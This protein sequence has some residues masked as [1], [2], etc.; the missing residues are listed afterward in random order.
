MMINNRLNAIVLDPTHTGLTDVATGNALVQVQQYIQDTLVSK[1]FTEREVDTLDSLTI[2]A[3]ACNNGPLTVSVLTTL[4]QDD[5]LK[6]DGTVDHSDAS[7][8]TQLHLQETYVRSNGVWKEADV[9]DLSQPA[10]SAS[11]SVI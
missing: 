9:N 2:D 1:G 5:Y 11:G 10:P 4:K 7:V 8:G 6:S 3:A